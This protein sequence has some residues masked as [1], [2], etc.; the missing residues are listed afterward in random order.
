MA[1]NLFAQYVEFVY[2][3]HQMLGSAIY[4]PSS[5]YLED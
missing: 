1:S 3:A 4:L 2:T 5:S